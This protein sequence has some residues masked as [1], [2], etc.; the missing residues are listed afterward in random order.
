M[1]LVQTDQHDEKQQAAEADI[2][3]NEQPSVETAIQQKETL[4]PASTTEDSTDSQPSHNKDGNLQPT[5]GKHVEAQNTSAHAAEPHDSTMSWQ[6]ADAAVGCRHNDVIDTPTPVPPHGETCKHETHPAATA[7]DEN[8]VE[9]K[10]DAAPATPAATTAEAL[11]EPAQSSNANIP[12]VLTNRP[13]PEA[14]ATAKHAKKTKNT[15]PGPSLPLDSHPDNVR[16]YGNTYF[17]SPVPEAIWFENMLFHLPN[18]TYNNVCV[19]Y[20]VLW[21]KRFS[22]VKTPN[23]NC[24]FVCLYVC[25]FRLFVCYYICARKHTGK[26]STLSAPSREVP[27]DAPMIVSDDDNGAAEDR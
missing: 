27:E 25:L 15:L 4:A 1:E 17:K 24:L 12:E 19:F 14:K 6:A 23:S 13:T 21:A 7:G 26:A 9:S 8:Q 2:Q 10:A 16:K 20:L 11:S 18:T 5:E 22:M 3:Q